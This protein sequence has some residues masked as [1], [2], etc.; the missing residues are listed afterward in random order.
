M[1]GRSEAADIVGRFGTRTILVLGDLMLDR[2]IWGSVN[3][4]SPEAPVPVVEVR[5]ERAQPGGA[6]NVAMNIQALGGQAVVCG[7]VGAD[8]AGEELLALLKAHGIRTDGVWTMEEARTTVKTRV[9][10]DRQQVV[11][12]DREYPWDGI[13]S[14]GRAVERTEALIGGMDGVI[15][16]DYGKGVVTQSTVDG[17]MRVAAGKRCVL[18]Y[19]PKEGHEL[20]FGRLTLATPNLREA[21]SAAGT[22]AWAAG[23]GGARLERLGGLAEALWPK[24]KAELLLI[25]LGADGMYLS[26]RGG[27]ARIIPTRAREVFDVSGAGDTV[28]ASATMALAAGASHEAAAEL[29]NQAAGLVVGKLGTACCTADE[30][31]GSLE[32]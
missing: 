12:V 13:E 26:P 17:L 28:I 5:E 4:I 6:A 11:R 30:L 10:A 14:D 31:L 16:E 19:D 15:V 22:G 29:A 2:Y 24:W 9:V 21:C 27:S 1:M 8:A 7:R 25:T 32:D 18:G 3:R 23:A 20:R